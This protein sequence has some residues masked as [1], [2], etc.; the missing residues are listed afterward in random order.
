M[1]MLKQY[2]PLA[3]IALGLLV[4][5][6]CGTSGASGATGGAY[7]PPSTTSN[8]LIHTAKVAVGGASETVLTNA[9]GRTLYYLTSD[10]A[11][12]TACSGQCAVAWPPVIASGSP[13]SSPALPYR[14]SVRQNANGRQVEYNG[15]LLYAFAHDSAAGQANGEGIQSA[16][17]TWH[18]ATPASMA[19]AASAP[20]DALI[21]VGSAQISGYD[22]S[23]LTD[24]RGRTLYYLT[25]DSAT[26]QAC[27]GQCL[28]A[29]PPLL[30]TGALSSAPA[31]PHQ[32]AAFAGAGGQQVEYDGHLLY[33]FAHDS[34]AGQVNG[35]GL[36]SA[37]GVWHVATPDL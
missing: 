19:T 6:A 26:H 37:G 12:T 7:A 24:A 20:A 13:D 11:T 17:G 23:V 5:A 18:V 14:L 4:L 3:V 8:A 29:W 1:R 22:Q 16:G 15:L 21:R 30:A 32:L 10:T 35:E 36:Q 25:S 28:A 33:T 27:V 9:A 2:V 34:A 31:L